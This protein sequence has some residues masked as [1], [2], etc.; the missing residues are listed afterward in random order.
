MKINIKQLIW[1]LSTGI[2][3]IILMLVFEN[4]GI[5]SIANSGQGTVNS[6]R[7]LQ[8]EIE[9]FHTSSWN[10]SAYSTLSAKIHTAKENGTISTDKEE[11]LQKLVD[12][13]YFDMLQK[14]AERYLFSSNGDYTKIVQTINQLIASSSLSNED[15]VRFSALKSKMDNVYAYTEVLQNK[16]S[17]FLNQD[18]NSFCESTFLELINQIEN[19][20]AIV[21]QYSN[22]PKFQSVQN[23]VSLLNKYQGRVFANLA[24]VEPC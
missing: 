12:I 19:P 9:N 11:N 7:E 24:F 17:Q 3:I 15:R 18:Y 10:P 16:I 13:Y 14:T 2:G 5:G 8:D 23:S 1:I 6:F 4:M 22:N 20:S 21:L